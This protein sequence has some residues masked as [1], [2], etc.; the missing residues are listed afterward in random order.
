M[1]VLMPTISSVI[2]H[3]KATT[4]HDRNKQALIDLW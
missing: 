2:I 1:A 3:R 4:R